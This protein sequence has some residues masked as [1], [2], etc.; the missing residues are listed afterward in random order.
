MNSHSIFQKI[1]EKFNELFQS[2][3]QIFAAPGRINLIGEHTDY[4]EGFVLPAAID[5]YIYFG[6]QKNDLNKFRFY[7]L[8]Y[9]EYQEFDRIEIIE[10]APFW[11]R[12]LLGV[13]AQFKKQ[14]FPLDGFDCVFGGDIPLGAGLSSSA[15]LEC[16]FAF[17]V[18]QLSG[19]NISSIQLVKMAQ[20]AEHEY[21]GVL[22]GIMDQYT[23]VFGKKDQVFMLD[24][25]TNTHKYF[26]FIMDDYVLAL[27]NTH[28]KHSLASS[29]Y[30]QRQ[31]ECHRGVEYF[32][33]TERNIQSL[34]DVPY[35]MIEENIN[36]PDAI[37]YSR[38][39]YVVEENERV[40]QA[41]TALKNKDYRL[42]GQLMYQS[43][44]GLQKLY[45]VSCKE[46]DFLVKQTR[47]MPQVLGSRMMG[48]GFGGCTLNLIEKTFASNFE[49]EIKEKYK[50]KFDI[51]A[52]VYFVKISGGVKNIL[53]DL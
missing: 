46:L 16:G 9:E 25:R 35:Q 47:S 39:K 3:A 44:E 19:F 37:S 7:S 30:N 33:K 27:V 42:F 51:N 12:Y 29:E 34:R 23:S 40:K 24:C 13:L 41:S 17:G 14:S 26:P 36:K 45:E 2:Q 5:K 52:D 28:V 21:A 18:N 8:D 48:G 38:C 15:A 49:K 32:R 6:I 10:E 1:Q 20:L 11:S 50:A 22:C 53:T 31:K 43:H 4:N